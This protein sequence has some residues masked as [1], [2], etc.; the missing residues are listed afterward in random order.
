MALGPLDPSWGVNGLIAMYSRR[1]FGS[2]LP[3]VLT[4]IQL[5]NARVPN[6]ATVVPGTEG[7]SAPDWSPDGQRLVFQEAGVYVV[8]PDGSNLVQL[9]DSGFDPAWS[10]D[11][12]RIVFG[13][14]N[15][16]WVMNADGTGASQITNTPDVF[17]TSP[18]WQPAPQAGYARPRAASPL[19]VSLVPAFEPCAEPNRSHGPPLGFDSCAPPDQ[20]A[21]FMTFG[22]APSGAAPK[23]VGQVRLGVLP[24]DPDSVNRADV[25]VS[26]SL[27]D[28]RRGF[29]LADG[30]GSLEL[31][32]PVRITDMSSGPFGSEHQGTVTDLDDYLTNPLRFLVPCVETADPAVGSTCSASTTVNAL[33]DSIPGA[34]RERRGAIWELDRVAVWEGGEDGFIETRDDNAVLAVQGVFVP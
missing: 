16:L 19:R 31:V 20:R 30:P 34:V 17:E 22:S 23:S 15:D 21:G 5:V 4:N 28:V 33:L 13:R 14:G 3:N 9:T 18:A 11:G 7:G 6:V 2:P 29:D 24:G 10:P 8:N 1:L 25:K 12:T 32:L 27:T 26:V